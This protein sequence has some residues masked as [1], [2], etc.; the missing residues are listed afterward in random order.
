MMD[1]DKGNKKKWRWRKQG[2]EANE[3]RMGKNNGK[4]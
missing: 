2:H 4:D 3:K 1:K